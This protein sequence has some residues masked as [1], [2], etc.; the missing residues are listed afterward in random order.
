MGG[1]YVFQSTMR[2][3]LLAA[4]VAA[5]T[6]PA[7]AASAAQA[8]KP[9]PPYE[10]FAGCPSPTENPNVDGCIRTDITGGHFQMGSKD[11]PISNP[12][13][14]VGGGTA[15]GEFIYNSEGGL[16]PV[17]Q[18]VPGGVVGLTG[19]TWLFEY[20][21]SEAL[22]LYAVTELAGEPN[23]FGDPVTLPVK[24]HL[25]NPG[26][27]LG[28]SCYVGSNSN[29][30]QLNLTTGTTSPPPPNQPIT[31]TEPEPSFDE[32]GIIHF[33]NGT[34]VDNSFAA[35]GA[36]G[37]WLWFGFFPINIDFAV[38]LQSGLPSA[39]GTNETVQDFDLQIV[40]VHLV[41]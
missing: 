18:K 14:L 26:G 2:N 13:V 40:S 3:K 6:T 7:L 39:A 5:I 12:M 34:F 37:C 41:Y 22:T 25:T 33:N 29:P 23:P 4:M 19:L 35:P 15:T 1:R 27:L 32:F 28:S 20:F 16:K 38:D 31:G 8:E 30:I 24:V 9:A 21:G 36:H 10:Q 17:K 11:V